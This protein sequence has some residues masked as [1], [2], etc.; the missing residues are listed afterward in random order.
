MSWAKQLG[1]VVGVAIF[2]VISVF[3][4]NLI[5]GFIAAKSSL[6]FQLLSRD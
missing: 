6:A 1:G 4:A 2:G 5:T 3:L